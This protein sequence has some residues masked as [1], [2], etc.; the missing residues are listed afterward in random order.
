[1]LSGSILVQV[2]A[3]LSKLMYLDISENMLTG[4]ILE[5][6]SHLNQLTNLY[7]SGNML[8]G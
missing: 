4:R 6:I 7:L 5:A 8:T 3:N 2:I 1:M